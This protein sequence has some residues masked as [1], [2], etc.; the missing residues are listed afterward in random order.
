MH[1]MMLLKTASLTGD[2]SSVAQQHRHSP[3]ESKSRGGEEM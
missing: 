3:T 1:L 2:P